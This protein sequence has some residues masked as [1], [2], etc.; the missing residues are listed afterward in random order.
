MFFQFLLGSFAVLLIWDYLNKRRRN[1]ILDSS[2]I[3]GYKPWP[4]VGNALEMR[5]LD[6]ESKLK[7]FN[8][9][10]KI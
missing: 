8:F 9:Y 1:Q 5:G 4:I 10:K 6:A 3:Q 7:C 2:G